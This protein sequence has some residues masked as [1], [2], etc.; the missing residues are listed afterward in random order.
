MDRYLKEGCHLWRTAL[1]RSDEPYGVFLTSPSTTCASTPKCGWKS[2]C[3]TQMNTDIINACGKFS[4]PSPTSF[5]MQVLASFAVS[6]H[7][8]LFY[9]MHIKV[10]F[11]LSC[12]RHFIYTL[13]SF[14]SYDVMWCDMGKS[15]SETQ[16]RAEHGKHKS[17]F[18][19][20]FTEE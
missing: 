7:P 10:T 20:F 14:C 18:E 13:Y 16:G 8:S 15:S 5:T 9:T 1:A 2:R 12:A 11:S 17:Y 19:S 3:V 4:N 6:E